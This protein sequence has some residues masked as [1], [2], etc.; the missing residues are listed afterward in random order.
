MPGTSKTLPSSPPRLTVRGLGKRF[1]GLVAVKECSFEVKAGEV[2]GLLGPNGSGKSTVF[3]LI[4]GAIRPQT[5]EVAYQGRSLLGLRLHEIARLGIGRTFQAVKIFRE[6]SVWEN[7]SIAAL[8]RG[9]QHWQDRA[10]ALLQE[11]GLSQLFDQP[12]EALS[13]GQQRLLELTMQLLVSPDLLLLDEPL[14]GVHPVVRDRIAEI[15]RG[16]RLEGKAILLIEHDMRFVMDLCDRVV[17]LDHGEKIADGPP[18]LVRQDPTV[19]AA[20]LGSGRV[21]AS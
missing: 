2:V 6:L 1:G 13:I 3:N 21:A 17:V 18:S 5:G 12:G 11:M 16:Q 19:V 15:I 8:G 20:L 4:T 9:H 7:L 10:R 14:A